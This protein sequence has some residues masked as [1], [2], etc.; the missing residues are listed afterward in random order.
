MYNTTQLLTVSD[1][2][3][4]D[5]IDCPAS[6]ASNTWKGTPW[7][8]FDEARAPRKDM[9][10]EEPSSENGVLDDPSHLMQPRYSRYVSC[11]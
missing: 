9:L 4:S 8:K 7:S 2:K 11:G 10:V 1:L 3:R 5:D 6:A